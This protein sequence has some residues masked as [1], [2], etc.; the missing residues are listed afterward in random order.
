MILSPHSVAAKS[1]AAIYLAGRVLDEMT[2]S[3]AADMARAET[4]AAEAL[5]AAPLS[6]LAH[7][8]KGNV[9]RARGRYTEAIPEYETVLALDRNWVSA[10]A[11]IGQCKL[12]TGS[13]EETIPSQERAIRL[14]PRDPQL[15]IYF[16]RIGL[17]HLLESRIDEAILWLERARR[18][19]PGLPYVRRHLA[20][21]YG[22]NGEI[23]RASAELA[24]TCK[25]SSD[26]RHSSIAKLKAVEIVA[27]NW[28]V[29]KIR[30]LFEATYFVG[31]RKAGMPEE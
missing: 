27:G 5:A 28:G 16:G 2:D 31:L 29:P 22:L 20:S 26:D 11:H 19:N 3:A 23:E 15:P 14:S 18:T 4:L 25:L 17:V 1:Y 12:F 13:I 6:P 8:A 10:H 24:E 30:A 21:A 7:F 9:L